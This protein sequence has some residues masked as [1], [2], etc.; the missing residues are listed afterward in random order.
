MIWMKSGHNGKIYGFTETEIY[1]IGDKAEVQEK[2]KD[3]RG[4][5]PV[6]ELMINSHIYDH[7]KRLRSYEI[8]RG[9][10]TLYPKRNKPYIINW[11]MLIFMSIFAQIKVKCP[12]LN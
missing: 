5:I 4:K 8:F 9:L 3:F 1:F 10:Q 6:D 2:L 12:I 7:Q 11:Q